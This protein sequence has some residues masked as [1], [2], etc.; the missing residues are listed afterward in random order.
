MLEVYLTPTIEAA[1]LA[2]I[3]KGVPPQY[4]IVKAGV[5]TRTLNG[6]MRAAA[7]G[8]WDDGSAISDVAR[9]A[10]TAFTERIADAQAVWE[11]TALEKMAEDADSVNEKTNQRDWRARAW[12]LNNSPH[13]RRHFHEFREQQT[14]TTGQVNHNHRMV[15]QMA[16][17]EVTE[18]LPGE[19]RELLEPPR[20]GPATEA[21]G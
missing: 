18:L 15:S 16:G 8:H 11:A 13:T 10:L 7:S 6:W 20:L 17:A 9:Q 1:A 3:Q 19:W 14:T 4:A 2:A 5:P 12:M 21:G